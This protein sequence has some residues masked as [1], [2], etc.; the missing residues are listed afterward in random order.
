MPAPSARK[1]SRSAAAAQHAA[2]SRLSDSA[3]AYGTRRPGIKCRM[4][5][6]PMSEQR[7]PVRGSGTFEACQLRRQKGTPHGPVQATA[8][9]QNH[10]GSALPVGK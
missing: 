3:P 2:R 7:A 5:S 9:T 4:A 1:E 10:Q 6:P 8:L